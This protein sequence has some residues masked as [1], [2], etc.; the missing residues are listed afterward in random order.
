MSMFTTL[1]AR[2]QRELAN[3]ARL[4]V[5]VWLLVGLVLVYVV[6]VQT[7]RLREVHSAYAQ[8]ARQLQAVEAA[9]SRKDWPDLLQTERRIHDELAA[10][11]WKAGSEGLAQAQLQAALDGLAG[12]LQLQRPRIRSGLSEAVLDL[13]GICRVQVELNTEF[14]RG[15]ELR[16]VHALATADRKLVADRLVMARRSSR[17]VATLSAYFLAAGDDGPCESVD[18]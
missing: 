13:P 14:Q 11:F 8:E 17:V 15:G 10:H 3:N 18:A 4:R 12:R 9:L 2:A 16:L 5:G 7:Q 1:V 6:V